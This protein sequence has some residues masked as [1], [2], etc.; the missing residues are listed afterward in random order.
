MTISL[1]SDQNISEVTYYKISVC[2]LFF[3]KSSIEHFPTKN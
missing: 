2:I 3:V 1:Y